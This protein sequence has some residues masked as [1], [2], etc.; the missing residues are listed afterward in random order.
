MSCVHNGADNMSIREA[1]LCA[2]RLGMMPTFAVAAAAQ[3]QSSVLS[4]AG[5]KC[6]AKVSYK[7]LAV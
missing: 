7:L 1:M 2:P 5:H 6:T 3:G 4:M